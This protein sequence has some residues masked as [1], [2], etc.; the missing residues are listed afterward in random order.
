MSKQ[1]LCFLVLATLW[2]FPAL[3]AEGQEPERAVPPPDYSR[4]RGEIEQFQRVIENAV[5]QNGASTILSAP[6]GAYLDGYGAVFSMEASL[7]R[8]RPITPFGRKH[9]TR[10]ELD[11]AYQVMLQGVERLKKDLRLAVAEHGSLLQ[12][13]KPAD[14]LAVI[15][16]LFNGINDPER[17]SPSQLIFRTRAGFISDYRQR[18]LTREEMARQVRI[19]QF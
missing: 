5:R 12:Q 7:Y 9:H 3:M 13:L 4:L 14:H 16:H 6:K 1:P 11:Q 15:V 10:K 2:W 8:I 17:P 18:K 19:R